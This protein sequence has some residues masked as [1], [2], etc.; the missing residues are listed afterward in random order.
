MFIA[1]VAIAAGFGGLYAVRSSVKPATLVDNAAPA[2]YV[3]DALRVV[4]AR[5]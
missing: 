5:H 1:A 3:L 2:P 4:H